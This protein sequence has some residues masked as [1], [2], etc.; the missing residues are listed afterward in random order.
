MLRPPEKLRADYLFFSFLFL[1]GNALGHLCGGL[2]K[3]WQ[4]QELGDF[5]L[6]YAASSIG[7]HSLPLPRVVFSYFRLPVAIS[8][9]GLAVCGTWIVPALVFGQGFFLA[10]SIHCYSVC[11]GR[12]G[13]LLAAAAFGIRCL[14]L[15]PCVFYLASRSLSRATCLRDGKTLRDCSSAGIRT[16]YPLF[17]CFIA[18]LIGCIIELSLVPRLIAL[19][20]PQIS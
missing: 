3:D 20:L 16:S 7:S 2:I 13:V 8:L 5:I 14:F 17:F 10:Y 19:V 9:L 11:L 15:L 1:L 12:A 18:L 6:S 4:Y